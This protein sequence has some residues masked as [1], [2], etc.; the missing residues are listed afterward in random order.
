MSAL[1]IMV[2]MDDVIVPWGHT[3]DQACIK[4]WG[5]PVIEGPAGWEMWQRWPGKTREDWGDAVITAIETLGLYTT[6]DPLPGAVEAINRLRWFGHR[7]HVVTARGFMAR[8]SQIRAWTPD[9]LANFG[10]G[11]DSL[12]FAQDKVAA[13]ER[14]GVR[15]DWAVDDGVHN[16]EALR[17]VGIHAWLHDAPHNMH[18]E[19]ERRVSSLWEFANLVLADTP[20]ASHEEHP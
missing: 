14:L 1:D 2:D 10:V 4:L 3:V 9:Y 5:P 6:V 8:S 12:T 15:F 11:H 13:Q 18:H 7:V 17:A 20:P 16:F 19:T